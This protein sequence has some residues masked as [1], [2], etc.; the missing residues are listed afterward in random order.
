MSG[1]LTFYSPT[2]AIR[3]IGLNI[4]QFHVLFAEYI[5]V[6]CVYLK[7]KGDFLPCAELSD[8]FL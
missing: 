1:F 6:F 8:L 3:I 7:T 5:Y 2:V 4:R